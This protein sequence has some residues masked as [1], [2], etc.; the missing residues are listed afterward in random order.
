MLREIVK[1]LSFTAQAGVWEWSVPLLCLPL[2]GSPGLQ[3]PD[4]GQTL[5]RV[6]A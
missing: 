2:Q 4:G 3:V 6:Q 5:T 1:R